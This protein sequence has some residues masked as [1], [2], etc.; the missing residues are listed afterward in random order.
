MNTKTTDGTRDRNGTSFVRTS[1]V[2]EFS[3]AF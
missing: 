2:S 1:I 3:A